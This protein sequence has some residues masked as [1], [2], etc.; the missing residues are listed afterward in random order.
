MDLRGKLADAA[1]EAMLTLPSAAYSALDGLRNG[2][3]VDVTDLIIDSGSNSDG[4]WVKYANGTMIVTINPTIPYEFPERCRDSSVNYP[5]TFS[6]VPT[7]ICSLEKVDWAATGG[8]LDTYDRLG[9]MRIGPSTSDIN[10]ELYRQR[11]QTDFASGD[12]AKLFVTL[13]GDY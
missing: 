5:Q 7:P 10:L 4:A 11:G 6:D 8:A 2:H 12:S 9:T 1:R 3:D 13:I